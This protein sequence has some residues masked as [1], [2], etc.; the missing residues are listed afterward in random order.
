[1]L[2]VAAFARGSLFGFR[3][4]LKGVPPI[5]DASAKSGSIV[6]FDQVIEYPLD[7]IISMVLRPISDNE[8]D[9]ADSSLFYAHPGGFSVTN[10]NHA[11]T[12]LFG[13]VPP[14]SSSIPVSRTVSEQ[15]QQP[16]PKAA[17]AEKKE[18][19]AAKA[20]QTPKTITQDEKP[21]ISELAS[22]PPPP[23]VSA[24]TRQAPEA[25]KN[26]APSGPELPSLLKQASRTAVVGK[27]LC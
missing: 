11:V 25:A 22:I 5:K 26:V 2:W 23:A 21:D 3:Y 7:P 17:T 15:P 20:K 18:K 13:P 6:A 1:M 12:D 27:T 10:I 8:Q 4:T 9:I 19:P 24:E 16:A 14:P